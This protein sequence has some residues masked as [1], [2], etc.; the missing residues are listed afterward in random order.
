MNKR[1]VFKVIH[2][3][4]LMRHFLPFYHHRFEVTQFSLGWPYCFFFI[5]EK[6]IPVHGAHHPGQQKQKKTFSCVERKLKRTWR[7]GAELESV[8]QSEA[9]TQ[10]GRT[11]LTIYFKGANSRRNEGSGETEAR[12]GVKAGRWWQQEELQG[13]SMQR[14]SVFLGWKAIP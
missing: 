8:S 13:G 9:Q 12:R 11:L 1:I 14:R 7:T 2:V 4:A 10:S 6:R 3:T 5:C